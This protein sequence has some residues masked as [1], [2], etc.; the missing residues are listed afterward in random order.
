MKGF[1]LIDAMI[2]V[3]ILGIIAAVLILCFFSESNADRQK[4]AQ[5]EYA[6]QVEFLMESEEWTQGKAEAYLER[7]GDDDWDLELR[8][9]FFDWKIDPDS[10]KK[11]S[12]RTT[13]EEEK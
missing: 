7:I 8:G 9:R 1:T 4:A 3:V 2:A 13:K 5:M 12:D 6:E 11:K 10:V